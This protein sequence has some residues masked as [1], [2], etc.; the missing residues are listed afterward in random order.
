MA[1]DP[2]RNMLALK[3]AIP[4]SRGSLVIIKGKH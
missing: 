4:G 3:G 2:E 1:V